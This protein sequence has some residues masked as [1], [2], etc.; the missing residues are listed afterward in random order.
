MLQSIQNFLILNPGNIMSILPI[1]MI[2]LIFIILLVERRFFLNLFKNTDKLSWVILGLIILFFCLLYGTSLNYFSP[3]DEEWEYLNIAKE[4]LG[5]DN[6]FPTRHGMLYPLLLSFSFKIFDLVPY[7]AS[8]LNLILA[9]LSILLVFLLSKIIFKKDIPSLISS[10]FYAFN[11]QIITFTYFRM[12]FPMTASFLLLLVAVFCILAFKYHRLSL[13]IL[14]LLSL[15]VMSQLKP[16]FF[17][18]FFPY[19]LCFLVFKEYKYLSFK[20]II[21][22]LI[23][24][25]IVFCPFFVSN[26]EHKESF[27][28]GWCGTPSQTFNNGEEYSYGLPVLDQMDVVLKSITN[29]RFSFVYL[30][31]DLPN[32]FNFW[33]SKYFL[34]VLPFI[35]LGII[36]AFLK[37]HKK[38]C[39]YLLISFLI[40]SFIYL[41]DCA[42]YESRYA[43]PSYGLLVIFSGFAFDF[44][45][46]KLYNTRIRFLFRILSIIIIVFLIFAS[47]GT[48]NYYKN[49]FQIIE[50]EEYGKLETL[51]SNIPP[52]DSFIVVP[53][54]NESMMLRFMGYDEVISFTDM[55]RIS[56]F[57]QGDDFFKFFILPTEKRKDNYFISTW[58]CST[59]E[60]MRKFCEFTVDNYTEEEI[61]REGDYV[62]YK[63]KSR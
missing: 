24:F 63:I 23:I 60:V 32:L 40:F 3:S 34:L 29:E 18:L 15:A 16:E 31:Y 57:E 9:A 26:T 6:A 62:L 19:L 58:H 25:L 46:E 7:V 37:G 12:G 43:I 59:L 39:F 11:F 52:E 10:T 4:M 47:I 42:Y 1:V 44:L 56:Y 33:T 36:F 50:T 41:A 28:D 2:L 53:H 5:G 27:K 14:S 55:V 17:T 51:L 30:V 48:I 21:L 22:L 8:Y 38:E 45:T 61:K 13:H 49:S 20:K 54:S 35:L